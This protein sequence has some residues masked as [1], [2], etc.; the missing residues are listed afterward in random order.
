MSTPAEVNKAIFS[1]IKPLINLLIPLVAITLIVTILIIIKKYKAYKK[2]SYYLLTK[3]PYLSVRF[4]LGRYG[5]YLTYNHLK[6]VEKSGG[7]FLFNCYIPKDDDKTTEIDVLLICSKGI[8]VFESKNY[9]G[10]IFGSEFQKNWCQTL[11]NGNKS[12]KEHFYNPIMQNKTHI[13]Y[14]KTLIGESIPVYSIIVFSDR[15]TLKDIK[16]KSNDIKVIQRSNVT[17][18]VSEICSKVNEKV[19]TD[20]DINDIYEKLY[21]YTQVSDEIKLKHIEDIKNSQS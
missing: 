3:N 19:L 15:C 13:K 5:E 21:P 8:F 9:S 4:D 12:R 1:I 11:P 18:A 2:S 10:W 7:K 20:T 16:L 17:S 6:S 14:L